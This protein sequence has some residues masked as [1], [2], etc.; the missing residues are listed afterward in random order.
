MK[1]HFIYKLFYAVAIAALPFVLLI[2]QSVPLLMVTVFINIYF[3]TLFYNFVFK[4]DTN[5][6][7]LINKIGFAALILFNIYTWFFLFTSLTF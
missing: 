2:A 5:S 7:G 1:N 3:L 4:H 6:V